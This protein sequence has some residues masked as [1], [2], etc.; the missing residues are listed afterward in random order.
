MPTLGAG[1]DRTEGTMADE[2]KDLLASLTE[3]RLPAVPEDRQPSEPVEPQTTD[4]ET[5][6]R[7]P[8]DVVPAREERISE[9]PSDEETT[10]PAAPPKKGKSPK[11]QPKTY[12]VGG[13]H[14]TKDELEAAGL[15][16]TVIQTAQQ[17]P[18]L[19]KKYTEVLKKKLTDVQIA[20][21]YDPIADNI[22]KDLVANHL[23]DED[24]AEAWP[25]SVKTFVGQLR[26]AFDL[27]FQM[28]EQLQGV[29]DYLNANKEK[30][31]SQIIDR[32]FNKQ[33]D[34]LLAKD[35]KLY[36]GLK[37]QK[38]RNDFRNFLV[39]ELHASL[40]QTIGEKAQAFLAKQWVAFNSQTIMDAAK[41]ETLD[42]KTRQDKR[43]IV[44]ESGSS[45]PPLDVGEKSMLDRMIDSSGRMS[46]Q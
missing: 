27:L 1:K 21:A 23:L 31:E 9:Q 24:L 36:A 25:R 37:D 38:I 10:L 17:F 29:T 18:A 2:N 15:L 3:T 12:E 16:D 46:T 20:H 5:R 35:A 19:Q 11:A 34:S 7:A 30:A 42:R 40:E 14:Y 6:G 32:D 39:D 26:L 44:G 8:E 33:L 41:Q 45:R 13:K 22:I 4:V 28:R 43:F